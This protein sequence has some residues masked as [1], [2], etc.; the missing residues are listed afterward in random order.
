LLKMLSLF[1]CVVLAFLS[2]IKCPCVWGVISGSS[3]QFHWFVFF[4]TNTMQFLL[5]LLYSKALGQWWWYLQ[6]FSYS[7][8]FFGLS[9]DFCFFHIILRIVLSIPVKNYV[10]ILMV[11][12]VNL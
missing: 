11:I 6:K 12:V 8:R 7:S 5:L 4:Y 3:I 10:G 1:H 9:W 2:K